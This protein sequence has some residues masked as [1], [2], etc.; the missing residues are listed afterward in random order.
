MKNDSLFRIP[1]SINNL[2]NLEILDLGGNKLSELPE[3]IVKLQNLEELYLDHDA[4]LDFKRAFFLLGNLPRL[5]ILHLEGNNLTSLPETINNLRSLEKLYLNQNELILVNL[6]R[7]Q[8]K[9]LMFVDLQQNHIPI[10][11]MD[12]LERTGVRIRF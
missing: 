12:Y 1:E 7:D 11:A 5:R 10:G 8:L 2:T 9:R 4:G 6:K 3:S